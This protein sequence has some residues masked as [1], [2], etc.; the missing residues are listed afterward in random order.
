MQVPLHP[1]MA[2]FPMALA[3]IMPI[4]IIVFGLM[5]KKHKM[6]PQAWMIIIGLQA[7]VVVSGYIALE[8]GENEE[9][10]VQQVVAKSVIGV[11]EEAAE[12]FVGSTVLVLALSIGVYFIKKEI[13]F[14]VKVGISIISII[15]CF[16]AYRTGKLG[17]ELVYN[18]NAASA[19]LL[20]EDADVNGL[21]PTPGMN[22][23]ESPMPVNE[24]ESLKPDDNEY[25]NSDEIIENVEDF[26]QED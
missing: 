25:S 13:A 5:I 7:A 21:L 16:L 17:G 20:S 26:K 8:T 6:S 9:R 3:F 23:S 24:N 15:S 2:H 1:M 12:I 11:H 19:Y 4:L 10:T 22:T 14:P 18:H